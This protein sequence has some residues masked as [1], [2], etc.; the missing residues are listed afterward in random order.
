MDPM[1]PMVVVAVA[2]ASCRA[3]RWWRRSRIIEGAAEESAFHLLWRERASF[4]L[5]GRRGGIEAAIAALTYTRNPEACRT[6]AALTEA[7][8]GQQN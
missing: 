4:V 5:A 7:A 3:Q 2:C 6:V 1:D 8:P